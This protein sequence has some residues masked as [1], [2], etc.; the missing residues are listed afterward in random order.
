V[1]FSLAR[2]EGGSENMALKQDTRGH[3]TFIMLGCTSHGTWGTIWVSLMHLHSNFEFS[4]FE[5]IA[6]NF[7]KCHAF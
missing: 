5:S 1:V 6:I 7:H 3:V 2:W 4:V